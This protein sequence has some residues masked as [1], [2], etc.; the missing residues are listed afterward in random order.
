MAAVVA[1]RRLPPRADIAGSAK[2][3]NIADAGEAADPART[4][5]RPFARRKR[6]GLNLVRER[7]NVL[8]ETLA[9]VSASMI[10]DSAF[11]EMR[12]AVRRKALQVLQ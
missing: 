3:A 8:A 4:A 2:I 9:V 10:I 11:S 7:L 6:A 5:E 12:L 1:R